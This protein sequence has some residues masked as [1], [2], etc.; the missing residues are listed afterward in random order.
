MKQ[1]RLI[2][3]LVLVGLLF[4]LPVFGQ[5]KD[6]TSYESIMI[7]NFDQQPQDWSWHVTASR[8]VHEGYPRL[9]YFE[10]APN[11]VKY[12]QDPSLNAK[13]LGVE[14][15]YDRKGDNWFE[16][17]PAKQDSNGKYVPYDVPLQGKVDHID[18][19]VWGAG[20][21]YNLDLLIRDADGRVHALPMTKLTYHGWRNIK[22]VI[23]GWLVQRSRL[24]G[25]SKTAYFVGFR[26]KTD[27]EAPVDIFTVYF[28]QLKYLTNV[29]ADIYDGYNFDSIVFD[30]G[31]GK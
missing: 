22:T 10:G 17:F 24:R 11:S 25:G 21:G 12:L 23:P 13:V 14:I 3:C 26:V 1:G 8:F 27:P 29:F 16:I 4:A 19:W 15:S 2:V 31:A 28:D 30:E 7:D 6:T 9:Q 20:Y 5:N 18:T